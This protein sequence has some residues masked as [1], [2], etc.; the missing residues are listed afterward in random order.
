MPMPSNSHAADIIQTVVD[1]PSSASPAARMMLEA[2][3][4]CRPPTR[5]IWRPTRGPSSPEITKDA[6]NAAKNQLLE[7]PRS[8]A[9]GSARMAGR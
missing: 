9:I 3:R 8:R 1:A 4:T 2:E 6:E 5:S 7:M